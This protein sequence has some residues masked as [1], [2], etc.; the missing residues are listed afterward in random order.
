MTDFFRQ[1]LDNAIN[2]TP[3][4]PVAAPQSIK[5]GDKEYTQE[6]LQ[7]AVGA[8]QLVREL[9]EKW[10]T[11]IDKVYPKFTQVSTRAKE[12]E[13]E[14]NQYKQRESQKSALQDSDISDEAKAEARGAAK[15]LGILT[16]DDLAELGYVSK[17]DF[18]N[19]YAEQRESERL[20]ENMNRLQEEIN[21]KDGRPAFKT[22]DVLD[23]MAEKRLTD[24]Q[25]A[26]KLM[27]ED[28]LDAW[29]EKR[30]AEVKK[31]GLVTDTSS[32]VGVKM[33]EE[34]KITKA[35][36]DDLLRAAL[37]GE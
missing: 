10:D 2:G 6:E 13:D 19:F 15:K 35:N 8:R 34:V 26:Y 9:E 5:L 17:A 31:P 30:I 18:K 33:P 25:I 27:Y 1:D 14:L 24:P 23:F 3:T 21:G 11:K 16:K 37:R 20:L 29:K 4:Q 28:K 36:R 32:S 12:L 22:A 7:E